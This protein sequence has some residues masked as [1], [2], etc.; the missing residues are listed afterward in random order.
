MQM[1]VFRSGQLQFPQQGASEV[2]ASMR[3]S[4]AQVQA[5]VQLVNRSAE[6]LRHQLNLENQAKAEEEQRK[7]QEKALKD[8]QQMLSKAKTSQV[9]RRMDSTPYAA[10][11]ATMDP[12]QQV[13][14]LAE[15][16]QIPREQAA[17][18]VKWLNEKVEIDIYSPEAVMGAA[19][20][21]DA[22]G[23]DG[24]TI[25]RQINLLTKDSYTGLGD[26]AQDALKEVT[27][28]FA[29]TQRL[30]APSAEARAKERAAAE[31]RQ[32]EAEVAAVFP[33][34]EGTLWNTV[35]VIPKVSKLP[36]TAL[37]AEEANQEL[38]GG[39]PM[40]VLNEQAWNEAYAGADDEGRKQL[41]IL[42]NRPDIT[43][44]TDAQQKANDW[45][46][47]FRSAAMQN[48]NA[49]VHPSYAQGEL[50]GENLE[51][52]R[53]Q[54]GE[55][56]GTWQS[57]A[58]ISLPGISEHY[59]KNIQ[60]KLDANFN[61]TFRFDPG[62]SV[63]END[64]AAQKQMEFLR[65]VADSR[66]GHDIARDITGLRF[67]PESQSKAALQGIEG[68]FQPLPT[69]PNPT[70]ADRIRQAERPWENAWN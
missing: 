11:F 65:S 26:Y 16:L 61:P 58:G 9:V 22:A 7:L 40:R 43:L 31:V 23:I 21:L 38:A 2:L 15:Q 17:S 46:F 60:V 8:A 54:V 53:G 47:K 6:G 12:D 4:A 20:A 63:L 45:G 25:T 69:L 68:N 24:D 70:Q 19:Q 66:M 27:E 59:K 44:P 49:N 57:S 36:S 48:P 34:L 56:I 52:L 13:N 18:E 29:A 28:H 51:E 50:Q 32:R 55:K 41:E 30:A 37:N 35:N 1:P 39:L 64:P 33:T 42:R 5:G 3:S 10:T 67:L 62:N 14:F